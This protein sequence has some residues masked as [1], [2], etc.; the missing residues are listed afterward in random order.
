MRLALAG[1]KPTRRRGA[2]SHDYDLI[3]IGAGNAGQA[4]AGIARKAGW[5]VLIVEGRDIGGTCP[6][7]GCVPKKVLVAAAETLDQNA[8]ARAHAIRVSQARP[9]LEEAHRPPAD[10]RCGRSGDVREGCTRARPRRHSRPRTVRR[11]ARD[12]RGWPAL[13]RKEDP[14]CSRLEAATAGH[15]G[16]RARD[17]ERRYPGHE[18]A[19]GV[20]VARCSRWRC[21]SSCCGSR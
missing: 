19:A 14:R 10:V 1:D 4:A 20:A 18:T 9:R 3:V 2:M 11:C 21:S 12:R 17:H 15:P 16:R 13:Q 6:L 8:R 5:S 7:R